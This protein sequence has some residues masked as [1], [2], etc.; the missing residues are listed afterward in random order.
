M[1]LAFVIGKKAKYVEEVD[2]YDHIAG[3]VLHN[4]YSER[5]FQLEH[6]GQW[7]NRNWVANG[8]DDYNIP[9]IRG[10]PYERRIHLNVLYA[11]TEP[12]HIRRDAG[13][14]KFVLA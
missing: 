11:D 2:A 10:R 8:P 13:R 6:G 4:D 5:A 1:E 7:V 3:Y 12:D 9:I 14:G